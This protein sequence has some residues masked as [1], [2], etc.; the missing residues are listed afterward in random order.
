MFV[1]LKGGRKIFMRDKLA[2]LGLSKCFGVSFDA[3]QKQ[4]STSVFVAQ[5]C[6]LTHYN[7][8]DAL[9]DIADFV[10]KARKSQA[11]DYEPSRLAEVCIKMYESPEYQTEVKKIIKKYCKEC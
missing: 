3:L 10:T 4:D 7:F 2:F 8:D 5:L 6:Q 11:K 9:Q 1:G